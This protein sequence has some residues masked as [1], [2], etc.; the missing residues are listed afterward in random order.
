[1]CTNEENVHSAI[2]ADLHADSLASTLRELHLAGEVARSQVER[3]EAVN[4]ASTGDAIAGHL[5]HSATASLSLHLLVP[6]VAALQT[7]A[8]VTPKLAVDDA[9]PLFESAVVSM[10]LFFES[11][12]Y[13]AGYHRRVVSSQEWHSAFLKQSCTWVETWRLPRSG[14]SISFQTRGHRPEPCSPRSKSPLLH[15]GHLLSMIALKH[16]SPASRRA[17]N[18]SDCVFQD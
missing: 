6:P 2:L 13:T 10:L 11:Y 18:Q 9:G 4:C 7:H 1:V 12:V 3:K 8:S 14:H 17:V 15:S 16:S 5:L